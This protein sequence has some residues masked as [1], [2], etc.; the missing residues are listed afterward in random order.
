MDLYRY[1]RLMDVIKKVHSQ[2][3]DDVC[4][5]D[6]DLIFQAA[7]LPTPDRRV[8]CRASMKANCE[9]FIDTMCQ[10][11]Q[12]KPY[13]ELESQLSTLNTVIA[14]LPLSIQD[15]ITDKLAALKSKE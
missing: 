9:R 5:M 7:N 11:G 15:E 8:G 6:I 4:W 2:H 14:S 12:W 10:D 13:A 1:N 3:A